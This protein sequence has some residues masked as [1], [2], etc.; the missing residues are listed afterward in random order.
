MMYMR[1]FLLKGMGLIL[2]GAMVHAMNDNAQS[3]VDPRLEVCQFS[4]RSTG[5]FTKVPIAKDTLLAVFGGT[6]MNKEAVLNLPA[7]LIKNVLQIDD[8]L[9]IG[10]LYTEKTDFINHSCNP[11]SG[12]KGQ[13][14]LVAIRDISSGEEITF[15]YATVVSEWVGMEPLNCNCQSSSCRKK[16]EANDWQCKELQKKYCG[17]FAFYIQKKIDALKE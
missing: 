13:I 1:Y 5:I 12:L 15:D 6:I 4:A 2:V 17:Y 3:W 16:I 7:R 9:W 10:S 11:N 8:G 14:C